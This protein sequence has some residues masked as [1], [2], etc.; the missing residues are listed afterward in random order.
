MARSTY[1]PSRE[2]VRT[3]APYAALAVSLLVTLVMARYVAEVNR[4]AERE[5]FADFVA[6]A[7]AAIDTRLQTYVATLRA[8]AALFSASDEVDADEF[9]R[10]AESIDLQAHYPGILGIGFSKR[11]D[12]D[13]AAFEESIR[14]TGRR[15]F[16]VWPKD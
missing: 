6:Q 12:G 8:G 16:Q 7:R 13:V 10:F 14:A 1:P 9:R 3:F 15:G 4:Q 2:P 5:Q 11:I